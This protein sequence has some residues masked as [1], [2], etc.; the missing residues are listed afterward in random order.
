MS[1]PML[2]SSERC[3]RV[4]TPWTTKGLIVGPVGDTTPGSVDA[5][6]GCVEATPGNSNKA[7]AE[8]PATTTFLST[9]SGD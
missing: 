2:T 3:S 5:T 6:R 7:R 9:T 4:Y 8:T 1:Y